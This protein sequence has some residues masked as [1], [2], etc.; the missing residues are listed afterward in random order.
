VNPV[1]LSKSRSVTFFFPYRLLAAWSETCALPEISRSSLSEILWILKFFVNSPL[2][3]YIRP[4]AVTSLTYFL[5]TDSLIML[6]TAA[7][8]IDKQEM[9]RSQNRAE[10]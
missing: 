5:T 4:R 2:R 6:A 10:W 7:Q 1:I 8:E 3:S 9:S